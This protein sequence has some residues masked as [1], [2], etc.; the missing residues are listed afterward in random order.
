LRNARVLLTVF[1][2]LCATDGL[3][4][5]LLVAGIDGAG[6]FLGDIGTAQMGFASGPHPRS[7]QV[8]HGIGSRIDRSHRDPADV[9]APSDRAD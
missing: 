2:L 6:P 8:E 7:A 4:P 1:A 3:R 5:A 9:Q